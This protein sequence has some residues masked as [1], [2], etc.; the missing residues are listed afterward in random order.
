MQNERVLILEYEKEKMKKTII[1]HF[2]FITLVGVLLLAC[3]KPLEELTVAELLDLGEKYLLKMDYE[4]TIVYFE[5]LIEIEPR[6]PRG[7]TGLAEAYISQGNTNKAVRTL[8]KGLIEIPNDDDF[9]EGVAKLFEEIIDNDTQNANAYLELADVYIAL[10]DEDKA[11]NVLREGIEQLPDSEEIKVKLISLAPFD[12]VTI[13]DETFFAENG[14]Q[15]GEVKL[16]RPV[17]RSN[18]K[19]ADTFNAEFGDQTS[20][21]NTE[22]VRSLYA[23]DFEASEEFAQPSGEYW[24]GGYGLGYGGFFYENTCEVSYNNGSIVSFKGYDSTMSAGAAHP[25]S[26]VYGKTFDLANGKVMTMSDIL[27]ISNDRL[28]DTLYKEYIAYHAALGDG[29]DILAQG[30]HGEMYSGSYNN[31]YVESVK[32]QC[33]ENAVFWLA[34]D[35]IHIYFHQYTYNYAIGASELVIPY[36]R[37][38]LIRAPFAVRASDWQSAYRVLLSAK[39]SD[40]KRLEKPYEWANLTKAIAI[41]NVCGDSTPELIFAARESYNYNLYVW[42]FD[43]DAVCLID[44]YVLGAEAG[45]GATFGIGILTDGRLL[46]FTQNGDDGWWST[47]EAFGL[48]N[49]ILSSIET[50]GYHSSPQYQYDNYGEM[51]Q[52][53][54]YTIDGIDVNESEYLSKETALLSAITEPLMAFYYIESEPLNHFIGDISM[55]YDEAMAFLAQ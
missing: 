44:A 29:Y 23:S 52:I 42:S 54:T 33:G 50:L 53:E 14:E 35:G 12:L 47:Y 49:G 3:S 7:Y 10:G 30:Y 41:T 4:Q 16:I 24:T 6:N 28:M 17:F 45:A 26:D 18:Y 36:T 1:S 46:A 21:L 32:E 51:P 8:R 2:V 34:D 27:L 13:Y 43:K 38:D 22:E 11:A 31:Y 5:R 15:Q 48:K 9:L 40:I 39:E 19:F 55:T 20:P 25:L 37:F